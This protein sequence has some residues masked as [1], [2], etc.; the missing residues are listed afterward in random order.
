[1]LTNTA[2]HSTTPHR[3]TRHGAEAVVP[4]LHWDS[5]QK[6]SGR[7]GNALWI[8]INNKVLEFTGDTNSFFPFGYLCGNDIGGTDFTLRF[9]KGFYE[10]KY[11]F[12]PNFKQAS[13]LQAEHR[14]WIEDQFANPPPVLAESKWEFVGVVTEVQPC[15]YVILITVYPP[16]SHLWLLEKPVR[17]FPEAVIVF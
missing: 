17:G 9:A 8:V 1:M 2:L 10:P 15:S 3:T 5:V 7:D 14:D 4:I 11:K 13:E 16:P 6:H 12:S